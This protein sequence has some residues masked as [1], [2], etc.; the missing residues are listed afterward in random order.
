MAQWSISHSICLPVQAVCK[1]NVYPVVKVQARYAM[2][3]QQSPPGSLEPASLGSVEKL[4]A[5][6]QTPNTGSQDDIFGKQHYGLKTP[7]LL[8]KILFSA[9]EFEICFFFTRILVMRYQL[10]TGI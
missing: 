10:L 9:F 6:L 3:L 8:G 4:R 2:T 1:F 5:A 7:G